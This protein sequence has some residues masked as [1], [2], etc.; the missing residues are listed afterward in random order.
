[1]SRQTLPRTAR[2]LSAQIL[3]ANGPCCKHHTDPPRTHMPTPPIPRPKPQTLLRLFLEISGH[4]LG[5][6]LIPEDWLQPPAL[7]KDSMKGAM[8]KGNCLLE[9]R[10]A[11]GT[12]VRRL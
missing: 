8:K 1:M 11:T 7:R 6:R 5:L 12:S 9:L 2:A 4:L 10:A 3:A